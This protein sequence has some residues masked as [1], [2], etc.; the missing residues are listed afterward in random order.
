MPNVAPA[1]NTLPPAPPQAIDIPALATQIKQNMTLTQ[2]VI[3]FFDA[4]YWLSPIGKLH[5]KQ[6]HNLYWDIKTQL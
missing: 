1:H 3:G 2:K 5:N 6:K 4:I